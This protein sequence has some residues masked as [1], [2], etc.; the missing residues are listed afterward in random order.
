MWGSTQTIMM[1]FPLLPRC[2]MISKLQNNFNTVL[3]Q[4][5]SLYLASVHTWELVA[6]H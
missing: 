3:R 4:Q 1:H 2:T 5:K 6:P